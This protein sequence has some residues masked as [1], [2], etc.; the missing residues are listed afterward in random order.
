MAAF[1]HIAEQVRLATTGIS[2]DQ[3]GSGLSA[4]RVIAIADRQQFAKRPRHAPDVGRDNLRT[5][6]WGLEDL[7]FNGRQ[8]AHRFNRLDQLPREDEGCPRASVQSRE[9]EG[10]GRREHELIGGCS[11]CPDPATKRF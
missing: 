10:T 6:S 7:A 11:D 1:S 3:Q 8:S 2:K 4:R 9:R 5:P